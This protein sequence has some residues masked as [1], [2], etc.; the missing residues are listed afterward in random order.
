MTT[1]TPTCPHPRCRQPRIWRD[2]DGF[3]CVDHGTFGEPTRA[4][5]LPT[6]T[7]QGA[8]KLMR[9][10]MPCPEWTVEQLREWETWQPGDAIPDALAEQGELPV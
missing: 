2:R 9:I 3:Y 7:T 1:A 5:D 4:W 8:K 10:V 6:E